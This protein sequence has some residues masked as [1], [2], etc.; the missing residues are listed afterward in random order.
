MKTEQLQKM[1]KL[2]EQPEVLN[3]RQYCGDCGAGG[4]SIVD[5]VCK[6]CGSM[7]IKNA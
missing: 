5:G 1:N 7:N 6:V 2:T 3:N 4:P